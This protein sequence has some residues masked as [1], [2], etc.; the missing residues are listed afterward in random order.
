LTIIP[1]RELRANLNLKSLKNSS[2]WELMN[3]KRSK[4]IEKE[5]A[6]MGKAEIKDVI[7]ASLK[8]S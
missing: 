4:G 6:Q 3:W 8:R 1:A 5:V 7:R 2:I